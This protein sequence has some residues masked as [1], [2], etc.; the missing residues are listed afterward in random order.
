MKKKILISVGVVGGLLL[1]SNISYADELTEVIEAY[2]QNPKLDFLGRN[3]DKLFFEALE[4]TNPTVL[5]K[6]KAVPD[7]FRTMIPQAKAMWKMFH[8][9]PNMIAYSGLGGLAGLKAALG[10]KEFG[11]MMFKLLKLVVK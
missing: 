5:D 8:Q 4:G 3:Y 10:P 7:D 2:I 9:K 1:L 6:I 11:E